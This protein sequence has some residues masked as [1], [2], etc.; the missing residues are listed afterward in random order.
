MF[1]CKQLLFVFILLYLI[2]KSVFAQVNTDT[3]DP[4][5]AILLPDLKASDSNTQ[6]VIDSINHI[7][8]KQTDFRKQAID[9]FALELEFEEDS[10]T[11]KAR[12][13]IYNQLKD[14]DDA[15][16]DVMALFMAFQT[17]E[18]FAGYFKNYSINPLYERT[19]T[20]INQ[21]KNISIRE[22]V[23]YIIGFPKIKIT[24][25][26]D[27][28]NIKVEAFLYDQ[29]TKSFLIQEI[30]EN[31]NPEP[32]RDIMETLNKALLK[33]YEEFSLEVFDFIIPN[34]KTPDEVYQERTTYFSNTFL[35][36]KPDKKALDLIHNKRIELL[37][38]E[39]SPSFQYGYDLWSYFSSYVTDSTDF[40][41]AFFNQNQNKF[42]AF[43]TVETISSSSDDDVE[44]PTLS[45][46]T[47]IGV[48]YD[49]EWYFKYN[50]ESY[51]PFDR[52]FPREGSNLDSIKTKF[53]VDYLVHY[54]YFNIQSAEPNLNFWN[55]NFFAN[56]KTDF[57]KE[58]KS[59]EIR[60]KYAKNEKIKEYSRENIEELKNKA[61]E[62]APYQ[63][64]PE[65]VA[66]T[67]KGTKK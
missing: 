45:C 63:G 5:I 1:Y 37:N 30:Y 16:F 22:E 42:I 18:V 2:P 27:V 24:L 50:M 51:L 48:K 4:T 59:E 10:N 49:R 53:F 29:G 60:L 61:V 21:L 23:R 19:T 34:Y 11:Y 58:I 14:L 46:H 9:N 55:M 31:Q 52:S 39:N 40:F 43:L 32:E 47:I 28:F 65:I 8:G 66:K 33:P 25:L 67:L 57:S 12:K 13:K 36:K 6:P 41:Q 3:Y 17:Q 44:S 56:T 62:N 64:I 7:L 38:L 35:A 26:K 15:V 54:D 20:D